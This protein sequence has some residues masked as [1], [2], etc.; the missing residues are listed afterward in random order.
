MDALGVVL[1]AQI[2]ILIE[3]L[4]R[5][6]ELERSFIVVSAD[7][8]RWAPMCYSAR[9]VLFGAIQTGNRSEFEV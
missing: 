9:N 5:P 7:S 2:S 6:A 1:V 4:N 3:Q 8:A